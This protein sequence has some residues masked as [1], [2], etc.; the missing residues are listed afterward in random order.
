MTSRSYKWSLTWSTILAKDGRQ[1]KIGDGV[2]RPIK[3]ARLTMT[4]TRP[5]LARIIRPPKVAKPRKTW[6]GPFSVGGRNVIK[7][8]ATK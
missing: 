8:F 5:F 1:T 6:V 7:S 4:R 3:D 2:V